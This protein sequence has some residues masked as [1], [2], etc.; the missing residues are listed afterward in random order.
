LCVRGC[1]GGFVG[2]VCLS[3]VGCFVLFL[4][5]WI[6]IFAGFFCAKSVKEKPLFLPLIETWSL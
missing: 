3:F 1:F 4:C 6:L 5:L 2:V